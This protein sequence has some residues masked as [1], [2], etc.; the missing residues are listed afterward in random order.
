[1]LMGIPRGI[2]DELD[3]SPMDDDYE[4]EYRELRWYQRCDAMRCDAML[5]ELPSHSLAQSIHHDV[6]CSFLQL[7]SPRSS[8]VRFTLHTIIVSKVLL[9]LTLLPWL[10]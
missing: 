2:A 10:W 4:E 8:R 9:Q 6:I 1:M 3:D 7:A 5:K